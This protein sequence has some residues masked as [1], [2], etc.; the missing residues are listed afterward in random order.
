MTSQVRISG[1]AILGLGKDQE[2]RGRSHGALRGR[3]AAATWT[4]A[5]AFGSLVA[6]APASSAAPVSKQGPAVL[7][8]ANLA[9]FGEVLTNSHGRT[10]YGLSDEFG[11]KLACTGQC[12]Q[13]W[14][15]VVVSTSATKVSLGAGVTGEI[16]FVARGAMG[17][18]VTFDGYPLYTFVKDT[19]AGQTHGE[20][21]SAFGGT[22]G[23][24]RASSL[25][26][27]AKAA[28]TT[29]TTAGSGY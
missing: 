21:V 10:V 3:V 5:L 12:L 15:P 18:Q 20:G 25:I 23:L 26:I 16:G 17:K 11:G 4:A 9:G 24:L 28:S 6:V 7:L 29:T 13:F 8:A 27:P 2:G 14:P 22:W 19:G 1:E